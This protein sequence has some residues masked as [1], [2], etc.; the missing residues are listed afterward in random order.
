[1]SVDPKPKNRAVSPPEPPESSAGRRAI[2]IF[3]LFAIIKAIGWILIAQAVAEAIT[4]FAA[5]AGKTD[6][7]SLKALLAPH[8]EPFQQLPATANLDTALILG[9]VG[10]GL[11]GLAAWGTEV[12]ANRIAL[13][14]KEHYRYRILKHRLTGSL[15]QRVGDESVLIT[16]GLDGLDDYYKKYWP[17]L[18]SAAIIPVILGFWILM[19]DWVSALVLVL[20]IPL[21]PLFM[22]LI[23]QHTEER[24]DEAA[25]G[26]ARISQNLY[27]LAR[28][29]P[30]LVGLHRAGVHAKALRRVSERYR[31]ATMKTL[32]S[33]FM[34]ALALELIATLSVAVIAVFIG[35]RLVY[36]HMDLFAGI[37][38]LV[39]AAE[40]YLPFRDIG[41]AYHASEDGLEALKRIRD[42][43]NDP[44]PKTLQ[45][46]KPDSTNTEV[47]FSGLTVKYHGASVPVL[48]N[49]DLQAPAGALTILASAS[50]TGKST[51]LKLLAGVLGD[52]LVDFSARTVQLPQDRLYLSQHPVFTEATV[53]AEMQLYTGSGT[54]AKS[55]I[56]DALNLC[57]A[58]HLRHRELA[59]LSPGEQRR[60]AL[61][62]VIARALS[63]LEAGHNVSIFLDEPTAH[64]DEV[65][66]ERIRVGLTRLIQRFP[67]IS[68]V[69]ASHD[70]KLHARAD[71]LLDIDAAG[72]LTAMRVESEHDCP[73]LQH[74]AD[75]GTSTSTPRPLRKE[76]ETSGT[77][78]SLWGLLKYLPLRNWRFLG[79]VGLAAITVL[80]AAALAA[81][82]G[83]LI[84]QA[85]Y[86]PPVLYLLAIIVGVR[87]FGI[88]RAAFRYAERLA[89]HRAILDWANDL[90]LTLWNALATNIRFWPT[91]TRR[92][93]SL[94]LL[95]ADVDELRDAL[96]R[97]VVPIPAAVIAWVITT[98]LLGLI[99]PELVPIVAMAGLI[100]LFLVP[101]L[102]WWIER[103]T[104][105]KLA[106]HR[107][108]LVAESSQLLGGAAEVHA[109]GLAEPLL[110]R[111]AQAEAAQQRHL[112]R[113]ALFAGIGQGSAV[114]ITAATAIISVLMALEAGLEAPMVALLGFL[115]LS[116]AEPFGQTVEATHEASVLAVQL[117]KLAP[118]LEEKDPSVVTG[119]TELLQ[120][121]VSADVLV[122]GLQT[123][124]V[125]AQ[126]PGTVEPV[127]A[128]LDFSVEA[129]EL[130]VVTGPSGSGKSTLLAVLLGFLPPAAGRYLIKTTAGT[131]QLELAQ[132][133]ERIAWCPQEAYLF[134]ST[135]AG[136]LALARDR[137]EAPSQEQM[138]AVL[139]QV[140]LGP[141]FATTS[142][143]LDTSIGAGGAYLS[144]GQRQRLALAR[145]LLADADVLL[146][147][148]PTAH[149]GED[150]AAELVADLHELK[151]ERSLVIVTH[152]MDYVAQAD[153][154]V[155]L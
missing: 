15:P 111:F 108:W 45:S 154:H 2:G 52:E 86:Q 6:V 153:R 137:D 115:L 62:R 125:A 72:K 14:E 133:F 56:T 113:R 33:A 51:I 5:L 101:L 98:I 123:Q 109:N 78:Q 107:S 90:R 104:Q 76:V 41:S 74:I 96:P 88:G 26:L 25:E 81:L 127:F 118:L 116:L 151:R 121:P 97:V 24:V 44:R 18:V 110:E 28:G 142:E 9:L 147:D 103:G 75:D 95:I 12:V 27:E 20:T 34:S 100:G 126:Y 73:A 83:W 39:L 135:L 122:S 38:V 36:G 150:E 31:A 48:S 59:Q 8:I 124:S 61:A 70:R 99:L 64:L 120:H 117:Q 19:A 114:F 55:H 4:P 10:A 129:G 141:W 102:I 138:I 63:Q 128:D 106:E 155:Q 49:A 94:N 80:A 77:S 87:F 130:T 139:E 53:A 42:Q 93:G 89:T 58:E 35:V 23:G 29:L 84:V 92:G 66:A 82:S 65:S 46:T 145:A 22:I 134:N 68:V 105:R 136:N 47:G 132:A 11:R 119:H 131:D 43:L 148:E 140:G 67:M 50:G 112:K 85:S 149:L 37:V 17:A 71:Q 146:L 144:G 16:R 40:V 91:L 30:A 69:A 143:G 32:R 57:S 152:Q 60:V 21:I 7:P 79:G 1:M 54:M 3:A 13:G